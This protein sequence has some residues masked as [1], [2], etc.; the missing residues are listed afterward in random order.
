[1]DIKE[2]VNEIVQKY[3]TRNPLKIAKAMD[4]ILV[5][6]PLDGVRGFY[7]YFQRNH[8]IYV[9]ERLPENEMLFVIAHELGHLFLHKDSNAIFMDTRTNFVTNKFEIEADRF[10][11]NLLIQDSD[12]EE[13]LSFT[14]DQLSRLFGYHKRMIELRLKDFE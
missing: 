7:H 1:M 5:F 10:A 6:H 4:A 2:R 14:T 9:D 12:I 3:G 13:Y 8:I 11:L